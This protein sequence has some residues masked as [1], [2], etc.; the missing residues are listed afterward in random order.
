MTPI[1][2]A[3][4][5]ATVTRLD[6]D[7]KEM[8]LI[9]WPEVQPPAMREPIANMAP[10]RATLAGLLAS[11]PGPRIMAGNRSD[12]RNEP[13]AREAAKTMFLHDDGLLGLLAPPTSHQK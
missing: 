3:N 6:M 9:P 8:P 5:A 10:P 11:T 7:I 1:P 13:R 4:M 12:T 2:P